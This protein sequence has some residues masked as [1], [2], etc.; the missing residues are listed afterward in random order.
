MAALAGEDADEL[1][2]TTGG[3]PFYVT[4]LLASRDAPQ[5]PPSIANA[6]VARVSRLDDEARRLVELVSVVPN[7]VPTAVLKAAMPGWAA[8]AE[9]PERRQL[10]EMDGE[11]V[12]FRH[13]LARNAVL[14][15]IPVSARRR[16]HADV[17]DA[18]LAGG[19][20]PADIVHHAEAAGAEDVV[21]EYALIAAR[22]AAALESNRESYFH[23]R[24]ATDFAE[25]LPALDQ[26][27]LLEELTAA[28]Y[29]VGRLDEAFEATEAAIAIHRKLGDQAAVGRCTR[30][31]S[32][33]H[34]FV[35]DGAPAGRRPWRRS[36]S[37]SRSG[38]RSSWREPAAA[39]RSSRCSRTTGSRR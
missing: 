9:E 12:R 32:R 19:A 3:N 29:L 15:S 11:H 37:S 13:E 26:A 22:R 1:Y 5:P 38:S 8:A 24:R 30:V 14:S 23:Y 16:L 17:L 31:L 6:V 36:G 33:L 39:W 25:H 7:R 18:L 35:G 2:A 28:A 20:D 27:D 21:S 34:W 4:E 10:L